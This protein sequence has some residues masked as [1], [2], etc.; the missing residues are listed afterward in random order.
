MTSFTYEV[1]LSFAGEQREYVREVNNALKALGV[2]TFYDNDHL[3][4]LWGKNHTEELPR[5]FAQ[6]SHVVVMFISEQYV[7][8]QWPRH[9]HRAILTEQTQRNGAYLLPV[10]FDDTPVPGLNPAW[11]Y[12][13]AEKFTPERLSEAIYQQLVKMDVKEPH[14]ETGTVGGLDL[15]LSQV[16]KAESGPAAADALVL[17]TLGRAARTNPDDIRRAVE[18]GVSSQPIQISPD[19]I[20][21]LDTLIS[22]EKLANGRVVLQPT[23]LTNLTGRPATLTF[24]DE[25]GANLGSFTSPIIHGGTGIAGWSL[26]TSP[27]QG[28]QVVVCAPWTAAA[29]G[30]FAVHLDLDGLDPEG[31]RKAIRAYLAI[32]RAVTTDISIEGVRLCRMGAPER[33]ADDLS[34]RVHQLFEAADDLVVIQ[35]AFGVYFP[36]PDEIVGIERLWLRAFRLMWEGGFAP[37]P[38]QVLRGVATPDLAPV[39]MLDEAALLLPMDGGNVVLAGIPLAVPDYTIYHPHVRI[40]GV[41]ESAAD[42]R[43]GVVEPRQ[44]AARPADDTP[45]VAFFPRRLRPG[46]ARSTPWNLPGV[47]EPPTLFVPRAANE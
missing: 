22:P 1:A 5:I 16:F 32:H 26:E 46:E 42:A 11:H 2:K 38:R 18:F 28:L 33:D 47:A 23:G 37:I 20:T 9:E 12:L 40:E 39:Q 13:R 6:D 30:E 14:Q 43:S 19:D 3:V 45:F 34:N 41:R 31:T 25:R 17:S 29:D 27:A 24:Q 7:D 15:D 4:D 44:F 36:M 35:E 21:G 8:K 10:R